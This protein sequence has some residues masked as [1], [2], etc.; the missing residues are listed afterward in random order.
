MR[1]PIASVDAA[2]DGGGSI[3]LGTGE[4]RIHATFPSSSEGALAVLKPRQVVT[5]SCLGNGMTLGT[6]S[7]LNC[8]LV[9]VEPAE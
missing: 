7:L 2:P 6:P 9:R 3:F 4:E 5:V 8:G 1:N